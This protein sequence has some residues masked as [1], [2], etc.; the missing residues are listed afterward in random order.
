MLNFVETIISVSLLLGRLVVINKVFFCKLPQFVEFAQ[1]E[2]IDGHCAETRWHK[3]QESWL[4]VLEHHHHDHSRHDCDDV[5]NDAAVEVGAGGIH[6]LLSQEGDHLVSLAHLGKVIDAADI[7]GA[8]D[9]VSEAHRHE[10]ARDHDVTQT[11]KGE[12]GRL[13]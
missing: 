12:L 6:G 5:A 13:S 3:V 2:R 11:Q 9:V 10:D 8:E 1:S 4:S 7:Q